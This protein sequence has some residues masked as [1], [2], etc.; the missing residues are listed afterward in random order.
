DRAGNALVPFERR[1]MVSA[2]AGYQLE[3]RDNNSTDRA[4]PLTLLEDPRG[5]Q[6]TAGHGNMSNNSDVDYWRFTAQAGNVL[7]IASETPGKAA[8]PQSRFL[9]LR[10]ESR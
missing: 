8:A 5:L 2:V 4:D 7:S 9:T 6:W 1:F 3:D 10:A